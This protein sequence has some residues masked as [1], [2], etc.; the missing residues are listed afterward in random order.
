MVIAFQDSA[1]GLLGQQDAWYRYTWDRS[2]FLIYRRKE[3]KS[4]MEKLDFSQQVGQ[5]PVTQSTALWGAIFS[6][7]VVP[8][9]VFLRI[10]KA[11]RW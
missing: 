9:L 11:W 10:L 6:D 2:L 4:I 1:L 5:N 8:F 3:L 7:L